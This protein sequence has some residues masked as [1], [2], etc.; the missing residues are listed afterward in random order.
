MMRFFL[1]VL[2]LLCCVSVKAENAIIDICPT[3][4]IQTSGEHP[5]GVIIAAFDRRNLWAVDLDRRTRYPLE[6]TRPCGTNCHLSPDSL[7]LTYLNPADAVFS[8]MRLNGAERTPLVENAN[9]VLWWRNDTLLVWSPEHNAAL[10]PETGGEPQVL[11]NAQGAISIQPGGMW[12]LKLRYDGENFQRVL[13]NL[14][15]SAREPLTAG[16]EAPYFSA[17]AWS[18]DGVWL[19]YVSPQDTGAQVFGIAPDTGEKVQWT[20]FDEPVRIGGQASTSG[21]SWS[22]DGNKLAFWV[23]PLTENNM[24]MIHIYDLL[25]R[26]T[27]RYC[28]FETLEHTSRLLWSPDGRY[29][30]F[31]ANPED[32]ARGN[33]L[34]ALNVETGVYIELSEGIYPGTDLVAWGLL[35]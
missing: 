1:L 20:G 10:I 24:S 15:D 35:P 21:L 18:P 13:V 22:P 33:L 17:S 8:K 26:E 5:G 16:I 29:L 2:L 12:A 25:T 6:D 31:R 19:A 27:R 23:T 28:G 9:E 3:S 4:G 11:S 32:D 34:I 30:A 14:F 7:W